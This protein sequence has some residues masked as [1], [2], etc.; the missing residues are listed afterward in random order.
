MKQTYTTTHLELADA[1]NR[2]IRGSAGITKKRKAE[3][4]DKR[5]E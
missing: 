1:K 2:G 5:G 4:E 3:Y